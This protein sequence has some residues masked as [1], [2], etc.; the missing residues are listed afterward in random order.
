MSDTIEWKAEIMFKGTMDE[1]NEVAKVLNEKP[2][3]IIIKEWE[4]RPNHLAGCSP[5]PLTNILA[6]DLL[7]Q[8]LKKGRAIN[9]IIFIKDIAGGIRTPHFHLRD[10]LVLLDRSQFVEYVADMAHELG[11]RRAEEIGDY[12]EVMDAV[13][14]L[15]PVK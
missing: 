2:V 12:I 6:D 10:Q 1:F 13:G 15:A 5:F 14:R 4:G 7:D 8:Y 11:K 3:R 9:K